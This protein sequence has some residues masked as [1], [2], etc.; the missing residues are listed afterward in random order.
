M[1]MNQHSMQIYASGDCYHAVTDAPPDL[2]EL[3]QQV[4]GRSFRRI[5]RFIQS[6]MIGAARCKQISVPADTAVYL[7]SGRG[8]LEL[9]IEIM[10]DLFSRAQTP[11]PLGFVNTVSNAAC[12]YL[13]QLL[14]LQSRSNYVCN[15]YFA[16]ESIM[17]LAVT[18]LQMGNV[19]SALIGSVDLCTAPL[20]DH[21]KRLHLATDTAI[22]E[23]SHWLWIGSPDSG[24]PRIGEVQAAEH[25][26]SCETLLAWI[27][28]Q[29]FSQFPEKLTL[30]RGQFVSDAMWAQIVTHI[31]HESVFDYRNDRPYYDSQSGAVIG[32]FLRSDCPAN[33]M[34]HINADDDGRVSAMVVS[35]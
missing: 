13:A 23:G 32:E 31:K 16:F 30:S 15:R 14:H 7:A 4:T 3:C 2:K 35:R 6:A 27:N 11:K 33:S 26:V 5:G 20:A 25:F 19:T 18:D 22:G 9:T 28:T 34:L 1:I 17:Q 21:K 12:F 8:D 29:S 10:T 24:K